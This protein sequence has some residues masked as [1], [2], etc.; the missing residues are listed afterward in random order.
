M[1][2]NNLKEENDKLKE[3]LKSARNLLQLQGEMLQQLHAQVCEECSSKL[4]KVEDNGITTNGQIIDVDF[5]KFAESN[6]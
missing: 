5:K 1:F 2:S 4:F 6:Q 3:T